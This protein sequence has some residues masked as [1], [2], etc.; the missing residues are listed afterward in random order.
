MDEKKYLLT[1][2][3]GGIGGALALSLAMEGCPL[4]LQGRNRARLLSLQ[5]QL[6]AAHGIEVDSVVA[7]LT[8][9]EGLCRVRD[10][11]TSFGV[12]GLINN[13]G[14]NQF[15]SFAQADIENLIGLNVLAT[16]KLTQ[17]MLP[18][19]E[20]VPAGQVINIGSAFGAIGYP[21]YVAY[22]AAKH[23]IKGFSE[24]LARELSGSSVSVTYVSPRATRTEMNSVGV[25]SMNNELGVSMDSPERV[26]K[27]ITAAI[28]SQV[29]RHQVGWQ[30]KLQAK[31]NGLAPGLVDVAIASQLPTIRIYM[32]Q[33]KSPCS[34]Y[35][36][37]RS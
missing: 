22:C 34:D 19:L 26:A 28:K 27:E 25:N 23:A 37:S 12:E 4:L 21:G 18:H 30:E 16:M 33:E 3:T 31:L 20:S 36:P 13:A 10:A 24:A 6:D 32:K 15:G 35:S 1:G 7:D 8:T 11:A 14:V 2:A 5:R 9:E 29:R 17:A